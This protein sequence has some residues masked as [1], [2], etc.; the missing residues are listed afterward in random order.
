[1]RVVVED[2]D[3]MPRRAPVGLAAALDGAS[4]GLLGKALVVVAGDQAESRPRA[5]LEKR[6][7]RVDRG[8]ATEEVTSRLPLG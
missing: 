6:G 4:D 7:R 1:V 8:A 5:A 2:A 3:K